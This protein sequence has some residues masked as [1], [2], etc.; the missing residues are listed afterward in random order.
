M[1][2]RHITAVLD[3]DGKKIIEMYGQYDGYPDSIGEDLKEFISS[4]KMVNGIGNDDKVFNGI[5]CFAAQLVSHFKDGVG[6]FYLHAPSTNYKNKK[7]Y[8]TKYLAEYYYEIDSNLKLT[9]YNTYNN[10][11]EFEWEK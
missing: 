6:G 10:R 7:G 1:G 5:E 4:G 11:L 8:Y 2:T 3:E 9:C